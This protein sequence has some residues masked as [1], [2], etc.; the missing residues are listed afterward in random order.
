[1][2][3]AGAD[4]AGAVDG[5]EGAGA[6]GAG[7]AGA[8][9]AGAGAAGAGCCGAAGA[10][11]AELQ[12]R[13]A[14]ATVAISPPINNFLFNHLRHMSLFLLLASDIPIFSACEKSYRF[15]HTRF[16]EVKPLPPYAAHYAAH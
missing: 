3:G 1:M 5:A 2:L 14:T 13:A 7:A 9:A 6:E 15:Y 16:R 8:G 12:A 4:G 10:S 11:E